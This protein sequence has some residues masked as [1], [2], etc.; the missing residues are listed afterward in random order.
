MKFIAFY[1]SL[2]FFLFGISQQKESSLLVGKWRFIGAYDINNDLVKFDN[3]VKQEIKS[4]FVS[5]FQD[6]SYVTETIYKN[7]STKKSFGLWQFSEDGKSLKSAINLKKSN[8]KDY[9]LAK[10]KI[11][12]EKH[13]QYFSYNI[14]TLT[15]KG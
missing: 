11:K 10:Q 4:K 8:Y 3:K 5:Y 6:S 9:P 15:K 1:F 7:N 2:L 12:G 13:S 14:N